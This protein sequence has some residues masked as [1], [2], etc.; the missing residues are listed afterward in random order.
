[1][2]GV[3]DEMCA[4]VSTMDLLQVAKWP[5]KC[6]IEYNQYPGLTASLKKSLWRDQYN[7][8]YVHAIEEIRKRNFNV[9]F[10]AD[11]YQLLCAT[12][13]VLIGTKES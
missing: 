8:S 9:E 13:M 1:M 3:G 11:P 5:E 10:P 7:G 2:R 6:G 12:K 4:W